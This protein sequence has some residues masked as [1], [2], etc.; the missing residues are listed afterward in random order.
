MMGYLRKPFGGEAGMVPLLRGEQSLKLKQA[1]LAGEKLACF[2][3]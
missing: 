3:K 1:S 2:L